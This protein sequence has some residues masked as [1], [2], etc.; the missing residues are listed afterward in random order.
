M[1]AFA[2]VSARDALHDAAR[3]AS[4]Q[5]VGSCDS[6]REPLLDPSILC[7][8][9]PARIVQ[10]RQFIQQRN[11]PIRSS[12]S[13]TRHIDRMPATRGQEFLTTAASRSCR[14]AERSSAP[15]KSIALRLALWQFVDHAQA[16]SPMQCRIVGHAPHHIASY[17]RPQSISVFE[18]RSTFQT[19]HDV[20]RLHGS[21]VH[22][23][24][25]V[26]VHGTP[27]ESKVALRSLD[28]LVW[29]FEQCPGWFPGHVTR[30]GLGLV[31]SF[32]RLHRLT[33][34]A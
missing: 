15:R 29:T 12:H 22:E 32:P 23:A 1:H 34:R 11:T 3:G 10:S 21:A 14:R 2:H 25:H 27:L 26:L 7:M 31:T 9:S 4:S 5:T 18:T 13:N 28:S 30:V 17:W 6:L 19:T 20:G 16:H 8:H 33:D 24:D